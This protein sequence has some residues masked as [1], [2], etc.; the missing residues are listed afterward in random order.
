MDESEQPKTC[1]GPIHAELLQRNGTTFTNPHPHNFGA[2]PHND[3]FGP[4]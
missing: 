2:E 1:R 3:F 4:D